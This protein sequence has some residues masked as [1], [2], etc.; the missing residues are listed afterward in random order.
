MEDHMDEKHAQ[1]NLN[2]IHG[3]VDRKN[4]NCIKTTEHLKNELFL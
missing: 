3:K 4:E 1:E 2:I